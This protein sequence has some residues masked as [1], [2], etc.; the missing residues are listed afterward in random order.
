M[1]HTSRGH[2][3]SDSKWISMCCCPVLPLTTIQELEMAMRLQLVMHV[4]NLHLTYMKIYMR[5]I[6][7]ASGSGSYK[8]SLSS[9]LETKEDKSFKYGYV[10]FVAVCW[11]C[12]LTKRSC[13]F[14]MLQLLQRVWP[15]MQQP[16]SLS[17]FWWCTYLNP[18]SREENW[19]SLSPWEWLHLD[20]CSDLQLSSLFLSHFPQLVEI[21]YSQVSVSVWNFQLY[22]PEFGH[23]YMVTSCLLNL[24]Y[25]K[26]QGQCEL[27]HSASE[28]CRER[29][30]NWNKRLKELAFSSL[31]SCTLLHRSLCWRS[32]IHSDY[33]ANGCMVCCSLSW[34][35]GFHCCYSE[36]R[37]QQLTMSM[38]VDFVGMMGSGKSTVGR[39]LAE[40]LEYQFLDRYE[41][42]LICSACL[43]SAMASR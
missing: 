36:P 22:F 17:S 11:K 7:K 4:E 1:K 2:E 6:W 27:T 38:Y 3:G 23:N 16:K 13:C 28:I 34:S 35:T 40:A 8:I 33:G 21:Y 18:C 12:I 19:L 10:Q 30:R 9:W 43:S 37:V 24:N 39:L 32:S 29:H 5:I 20:P 41:F 26:E 15:K 31:V 25:T 14:V 42:F